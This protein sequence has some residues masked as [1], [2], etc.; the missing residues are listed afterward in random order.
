MSA[1]SFGE[2]IAQ[3]VSKIGHSLSGNAEYRWLQEQGPDTLE[4]LAH[5]IGL[6]V[7]DLEEAMHADPVSQERVAKMMAQF[8]LN[9]AAIREF[10]PVTERDITR[11]CARCDHKSRCDHE[12]ADGTAAQH[13]HEFCL[14]ADSFAECCSNR[15]AAVARQ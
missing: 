11:L 6:S 13:A 12:L 7:N 8:G 15:D 10:S 1:H 2:S 4:A 9:E 5:D 3:F 14:N